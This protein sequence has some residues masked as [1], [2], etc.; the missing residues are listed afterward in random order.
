MMDIRKNNRLAEYD[1]SSAGAYFITLCTK[2]KLQI[3]WSNFVGADIIRP[4]DKNHLSKCGLVADKVISDIPLHYPNVTV[5][6]YVIMPNH[7]HMLLTIHETDGRIISAP[8]ISTVIGQMKRQISK[9]LGQSIWQKSFHDHIIR[10]Q[11]DYDS[12]WQYIDENPQKWQTDPF[13][14]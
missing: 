8:T 14:F 5:D 1:Y 10:N 12:V 2:D 9:L 7:I 13:Y 4:Q 3:F 6:K 11:A